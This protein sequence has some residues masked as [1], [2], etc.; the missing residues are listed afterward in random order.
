MHDLAIS[1]DAAHH[2][3]AVF[4]VES[5]RFQVPLAAALGRFFPGR[6]R[7]F[8]F[9]RDHL[10]AVAMFL[11]VVGDRIAFANG[12]GQNE[13]ELVLPNRITGAIFDSGFRS[14][15]CETL[16]TKNAFVKMRRLLGVTDVKFN[17]IRALERQEIF[18]NLR[19]TLLFWSSNCRCHKLP[20]RSRASRACS[21]YKIDNPPS[22][23]CARWIGRSVGAM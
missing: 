15:V 8:Y 11:N 10:D 23:G 19:G 1:M 18:R 17:V 2:D 14:A 3:F 12:S 7:V 13:R 16:K 6:G 5:L 20:P 21:K 22:Q 9:Q 4:V